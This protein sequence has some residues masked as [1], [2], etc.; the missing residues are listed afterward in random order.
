MDQRN[1]PDKPG[2]PGL[3]QK[4]ASRKPGSPGLGHGTN[5]SNKGLGPG[6]PDPGQN[7]CVFYSPKRQAAI[8]KELG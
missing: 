5:T 3:G 6:H 4:E 2:I 1:K 7:K 8:D